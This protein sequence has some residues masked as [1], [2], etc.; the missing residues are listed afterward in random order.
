MSRESSILAVRPALVDELWR[1]RPLAKVTRDYPGTRL[2]AL[3]GA[4][5]AEGADEGGP[6]A[7]AVRE[8][9]PREARGT[10]EALC[11][12]VADG[13]WDL[14]GWALRPYV[15]VSS[16]MTR[17]RTP[18]PAGLE[19]DGFSTPELYVWLDGSADRAGV[20]EVQRKLKV[21]ADGVIGG[22]DPDLAR[23]VCESL[24]TLLAHAH[25]EGLLVLIEHPQGL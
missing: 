20:E 13:V 3:C 15:D 2:A 10:F 14:P 4:L 19:P 12:T 7:E 23:D 5:Q 25:D 9:S 6:L 16:V 24:A 17:G 1:R 21:A 22:A 8:S 11:E 18:Y